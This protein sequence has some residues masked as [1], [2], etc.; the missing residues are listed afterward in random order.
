MVI[1]LNS[2]YGIVV[3]YWDG[4]LIR[5]EKYKPPNKG[6]MWREVKWLM[7]LRDTLYNQG[8]ITQAQINTYSALVR[9]MLSKSSK[10][11]IQQTVDRVVRRVRRIAKGHGKEPLVLIDVP[12]DESLRGSPLQRTIR[13]FAQYL[14]NVLSWYGIYWEEV[15]LYSTICPRCGARLRLVEK[16]RHVRI[17]A[18]PR[19][20]FSEDR[21]K[22]PLHWAIKHLTPP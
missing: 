18:C 6:A 15:R 4:K 2:S 17:M 7:K 21:D 5:T 3:H 20:G 10:A 13:S 16:T 22:V 12:S 8:T 1:D 14:T 19:C 9:K 11:W